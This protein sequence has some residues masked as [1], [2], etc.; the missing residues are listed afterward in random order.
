MMAGPAVAG[1]LIAVVG[2]ASAYTV[3]VG[4]YFVAVIVFAGIA[5]APPVAGSRAAST[6]SV[7]EGLRFLRGHSVIMSTF[8]IDLLAMVFGMPRALFPA[9]AQRLGR[10]PGDVRAPALVGRGRRVR[11]VVGEWLDDS[12]AT[13]GTSRCCGR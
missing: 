8:G 13:S 11:R 10:R 6:S 9:L 1:V 7:I 4:T 3:D 2:L 12:G 5:P